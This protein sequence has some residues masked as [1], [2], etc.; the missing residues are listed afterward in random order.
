MKRFILNVLLFFAFIVAIDFFVGLVG[1]FFVNHSKGGRTKELNDLVMNDRHDIIVMGSSRAHHHYDSPYLSDVLNR[2]VYNAGY[3][4][5][6][7]IL[8]YGILNLILDKYKPQMIIYDTE[9]AFDIYEYKADNKN[10]RYISMLKPYYRAPSIGKIIKDIS[11][12]DWHEIHSGM[13]RYNSNIAPI[14]IDNIFA[15]PMSP[16][17]YV[18][19]YGILDYTP[20][21]KKNQQIDLKKIEYFE[22]MVQ[23]VVSK[24][25]PMIVMASPKYGEKDSKALSPVISICKRYNVPF[26]DYYADSAFM[27]HKDW[28]KD[29][30][31][32]NNKGARE[33]SK[34]IAGEINSYLMKT[35]HKKNI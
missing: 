33:Y 8:A 10:K 12:E 4:G 30:T 6:G 27:Q 29:V 16:G 3:N 1:D 26:L 14:F 20:T 22:K 23:L 15:R 19:L 9:P 28:F 18:P 31:H 13:I 35:E 21:N 34:R 24:G 7:V 25:V 17:G 11:M 2:D 5:N 32:L